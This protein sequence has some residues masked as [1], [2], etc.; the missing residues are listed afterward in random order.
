L[1][2]RSVFNGK[3][4]LMAASVGKKNK[5]YRACSGVAGNE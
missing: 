2:G 3:R 4:V 1:I 5:A